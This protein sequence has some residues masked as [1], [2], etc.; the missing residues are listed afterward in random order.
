MFS[1]SCTRGGDCGLK[2]I[3]Y[4]TE[5]GQ[6]VPM[7]P[8]EGSQLLKEIESFSPGVRISE[9][10]EVSASKTGRVQKS[11]LPLLVKDRT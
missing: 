6:P 7:S 10:G 11:G 1:A 8:E 9:D 2:L 3:P 5:L 4:R